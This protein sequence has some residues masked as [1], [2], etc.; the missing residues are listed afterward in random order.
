[1]PKDKDA[2][3]KRI[4]EFG[5]GLDIIGLQLRL[6][7]IDPSAINMQ[8]AAEKTSSIPTRMKFANIY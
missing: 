4:L 3:W 2:E 7:F 6:I 8:E 1:M 5:N